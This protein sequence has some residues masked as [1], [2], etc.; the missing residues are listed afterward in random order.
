M[1]LRGI[2]L[3][4]CFSFSLPLS[5]SPLSTPKNGYSRKKKFAQ[6]QRHTRNVTKEKLKTLPLFPSEANQ[7][8]DHG[9][10]WSGRNWKLPVSSFLTLR[11]P[12]SL[13][14]PYPLPHIARC[15][16]CQCSCYMLLPDYMDLYRAE[17][18]PK[19]WPHKW[20]QDLS[21]TWWPNGLLSKSSLHL[22][23]YEKPVFP[24]W[25]LPSLYPT[26]SDNSYGSW[27]EIHREDLPPTLPPMC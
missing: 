2:W 6:V 8:G 21:K 20:I 13:D 18:I 3:S 15:Q 16:N 12:Y 24:R 26:Y 23:C 14:I 7:V 27:S 9:V 22:Q 11:P 5:S 1:V 17:A 4:H 19:L 25:S 10:L